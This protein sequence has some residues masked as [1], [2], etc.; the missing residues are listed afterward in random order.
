[1]STP[2]L[3][4]EAPLEQSENRKILCVDDEQ[5][6]LNALKRLFR[7]KPY[8]IF[9]ANSPADGLELLEENCFD[10]I[11]SDMR[12]PE[13]SGAEF[14]AK[15]LDIHPDCIR[16]LLTGYSD[17]E[18]TISAI[19]TGK[20]YRYVQKP[21]DNDELL[22][23]VE[24]GLEQ[25]SLKRENARL[26]LEV[27]EKN[28]SLEAFNHQLED[29]VQLR[30]KQ[31]H[32]ALAK[33]EKVN[34]ALSQ[35][36]RSTVKSFYNVISMTPHLGG[37][38]AFD[39]AELCKKL[40]TTLECSPKEIR[41]TYLA[42]LLHQ[43]GL[44]GSDESLLSTP[45]QQLSADE[46]REYFSHPEKAVLVLAPAQ[47]LNAVS[48]LIKH[49][50]ERVDATGLPSKL[51]A[52]D[53]PMG[54]LIL[55]IARDY[56]MALNGQ[57][58]GTR[59]SRDGALEHLH[60]LSGDIYDADILK[61]LPDFVENESSEVQLGENEQKLPLNSIKP[62]MKLTRNLLN[63]RD[64]LLLA[65]GH[66]FTEESKKRLEVFEPSGGMTLEAYV[67]ANASS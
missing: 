61:I 20:I 25:L 59:M 24:Q 65:E 5:S 56:Y 41:A 8:E 7:G 34:A 42:G 3:T 51:S 38:T 4:P 27:E 33:V 67:I 11:I 60:G 43:L 12:M 52:Q 62:G 54:S 9:L 19:N 64:I 15:S 6:V 13:M 55:A 14:L 53:I 57:L 40:A 30:T 48:L 37:K 58:T 45:W 31:I 29:K 28:K 16:I 46:E 49:Q 36:L 66:I 18:S 23:T 47:G 22:L 39:T 1:M 10:L 32:Q 35:S 50:F 2:N 26:M 21:W 44:I 17:I 63:E